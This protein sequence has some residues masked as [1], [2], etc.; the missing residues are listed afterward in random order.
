MP[1][2]RGKGRKKRIEPWMG[3]EIYSRCRRNLDK[4]LRPRAKNQELLGIFGMLYCCFL[5]RRLCNGR[6]PELP[7]ARAQLELDPA[8]WRKTNFEFSG[9]VSKQRKI[10]IRIEPGEKFIFSCFSFSSRFSFIS[11]EKA[12]VR[13]FCAAFRHRDDKGEWRGKREASFIEFLSVKL[14]PT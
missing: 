5:L 14:K 6:E 2:W 12:L 10:K 8:R 11:G 9:F 3:G 4:Q 7:S 13:R 1:A